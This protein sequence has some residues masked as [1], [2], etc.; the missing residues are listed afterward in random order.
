MNIFELHTFPESC[1]FKVKGVLKLPNR[2][3]N[4][5]CL[6]IINLLTVAS[7]KSYCLVISVIKHS[8][9][10]AGTFFRSYKNVILIVGQREPV[11]YYF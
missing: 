2:E 11:L 3:N 5:F 7:K 9:Y 10:K 8:S 4:A 1:M 6:K